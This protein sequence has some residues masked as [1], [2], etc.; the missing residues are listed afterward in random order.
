MNKRWNP[1]AVYLL[2]AVAYFLAA[3]LSIVLNSISGNIAF[4]WVSGAILLTAL[5][6]CR[7]QNWPGLITS[8]VAADLSANIFMGTTPSASAGIALVGVLEPLAVVLA[9]RIS[10]DGRP[11]FASTRWILVFSASSIA[12]SL[13]AA[14]LGSTWL[15]TLG[16]ASFWMVWQTWAIADLLG[17]L[18]VTPFLL[19]WTD[20]TLR[21]PVIGLRGLEIVGI[22]AVFSLAATAV[23]AGTAPLFFVLFPGLVLLAIRGSLLGAT[24]GVLIVTVIASWFTLRGAGPIDSLASSSSERVLLL[25]LFLLSAVVAPLSIAVMLA[26]RRQLANSLLEQTAISRAALDNMTQGLSMFDEQHRLVSCNKRY[27]DLYRL[28]SD[29]CSWRP[30][31]HELLRYRVRHGIYSGTP[32][33]YLAELDPNDGTN[34]VTEIG[35]ADGRRVEIKRSLLPGG[36]WVSTHEDVTDRRQSEQ[37][38]G[39]LAS[40]D[41]LTKLPN[42]AMFQRALDERFAADEQLPFGLAL[43]DLDNFKLT[44]DSLGHDAGDALLVS[45]GQR[46]RAA[47]RRCDLVARLGGDEFAVLFTEITTVEQLDDVAS[48]LLKRLSKPTEYG[49]RLIDGHASIGATLFNVQ[50]TAQDILKQADLALY[51][52]KNA[53]RGVYRLYEPSMHASLL[54]N[55]GMLST[56]RS[57]LSR[58][59]IRPFYQPKVNLR[60]GE[61]IGFEALLRCCEPGRRP[62]GPEC[63]G[64]AFEDLGLA[65]QISD[66]IIEQVVAD[67][68]RWLGTGVPFGHVAIN[69]SSSELRCGTFARRL[70]TKLQAAAIPAGCIQIEVTEGVL[71]GRGVEHVERSFLELADAGIKLALDDFGTGFA[72]LTHL[73]QFP[74]EIIKID[75]AFIRDLEVD[76]DDAAIVSALVGLAGALNIEVVAEGIETIAQRDFLSA[77]GCKTGQGYLFGKAVPATRVAV[78]L[79]PGHRAEAA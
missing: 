70:L 11:W 16:V 46:I 25:Q 40:H 37:R 53:G 56:A 67:V 19:S 55:Q 1:F 44:N 51:A 71:M 5:I 74:V 3:V 38:I 59:I 22:A 30:S 23:F 50:H 33:T 7:V 34:G 17:L 79:R 15:Q 63:L 58:D 61:I 13:G 39:Y 20:P 47:V 4:F 41:P 49:G 8:A 43:L 78:M 29:L 24:T 26:Q 65:I 10:W 60:T 31:L 72:S 9:L 12:A 6:R 48:D 27:K 2:V 42:R 21:R 18:V 36:G 69:A 68:S 73:K 64:A 28:P 45:V 32:E 57:G 62:V 54:A 52:A 75:R 14:T 66:R 77:L 76:P 35:L